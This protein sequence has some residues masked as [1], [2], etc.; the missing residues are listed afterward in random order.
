VAKDLSRTTLEGLAEKLNI[1]RR[2]ISRVLRGEGYVAHK[3]REKILRHMEREDYVP[4]VNASD[5]ASGRVRTVGLVIPREIM[6][7]TIDN[8]VGTIIQVLTDESSQNNH[9]LS[10]HPSQTFD[11]QD[12]L[13]KVKSRTLGGLVLVAW[14]VSEHAAVLK[15][16]KAQGV[17]LV[18]L[19]MQCPGVD[20][21]D[22]DD[23]EGGYL[24]TKHL[25]DIGRR[26]IAFLHGDVHWTSSSNRYAGYERA[27]KEAGLAVDPSLVGRGFFDIAAAESTLSVMLS[28]GARPDALFAANDLMAIGALKALKKAGLRVPEDVAVA[29]FDDIPLCSLSLMEPT[30]TSV[31][32]PLEE[33]SRTASSRLFALMS[34]ENPTPENRLFTPTLV[35]RGSSTPLH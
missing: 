32:M 33:I 15:D 31:R 13:K 12:C 18:L 14:G 10:L 23:R 27:L 16:L 4:N 26:R 29:G 17:P 34:G 6:L 3:T 2:T 1:S 21:Y 25:L 9:V 11:A 30:I 35:V 28:Q 7:G 5:L 24:A 22:C 19:N 8:Y 20:S